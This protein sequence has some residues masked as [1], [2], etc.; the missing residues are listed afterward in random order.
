MSYGMSYGNSFSLPFQQPA[1]Y[2][3]AAVPGFNTST[4]SQLRAMMEQ[5]IER[6]AHEKWLQLS[7]TDRQ[8]IL[9]A[10]KEKG[11]SR[12]AHIWCLHVT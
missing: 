1:N 4:Q 5:K 8:R 7:D 12:D 11:M 3:I 2:N 10:A 6:D 9:A